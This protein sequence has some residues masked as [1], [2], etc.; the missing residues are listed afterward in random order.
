M[1]AKSTNE[2]VNVIEQKRI[3]TT[4][5]DMDSQKCNGLAMIKIIRIN[6]PLLPCVLLANKAEQDL[7]GKALHLNVSGVVDK[8][9]QMNVLQQL[10]D[11]VFMKKYNS[12]I[13]ADETVNKY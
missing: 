5:I 1:V 11:R 12:D 10:L 3:H 9:V 8:P 2:F 4:I 13:F 7:L 6:Y